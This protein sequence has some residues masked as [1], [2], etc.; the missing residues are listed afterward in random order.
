MTNYNFP[1]LARKITFVLFLTQSLASAGFIAAAI[2]NPILGAELG[3]SKAW[4]GVPTAIYLLSGAFAASFWGVFMDRSGRRNGIAV[5]MVIGVLGTALVVLAVD[6]NALPL[7]LL[8]MVCM[9]MANS[10]VQLGRFAAAEVNLTERRG[11]A[12]SNVVI[13]GT[14]GA[15]FGPILVQP[16]GN[17]VATHG[18]DQLAGA[19]FA[20]G[21]LFIFATLAVF[22]GLRPDP[23]DIGRALAEKF[24]DVTQIRRR[25]DDKARPLAE[26]LRQPAV[27]TAII[28]MVL[29]Q[30]VMVAVMVITS[31][32]MKDNHHM[33]GDISMVISAH[34]LGM[35]AFS[36]I[37]GR[38]ADR[39]GRGP[40][41]LFGASTLLLACLTAPIS[42][43]VLPLAV[44]LFLLGLGW[45]FCFVGGSTLLADQLSPAERARTQGTSDMLVGLASATASLSSGFIYAASGYTAIA[46]VGAALSLIPITM[47]ILWMRANKKPAPAL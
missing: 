12:I 2:L 39:F 23:R 36:I 11:A 19:Y 43:D 41:I 14:V 38:L 26:I 17:F 5:G 4:T 42:P 30:V 40:V 34:T 15:V 27:Q 29:G 31:Q 46:I 16:M 20:A 10:A 25:A 47:I 24:P 18:M 21:I 13:G 8:G 37:S 35:Y 7:F 44:S 45:N 9:G 3:G 28:S 33:L 1:R 22:L 6:A 32:H